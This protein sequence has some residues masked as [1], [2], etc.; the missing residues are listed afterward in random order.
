MTLVKQHHAWRAESHQCRI[1]WKPSERPD[2]TGL[3]AGGLVIQ[4]RQ[5]DR[6]QFPVS[7][8]QNK[9]ADT[10]PLHVASW[11]KKTKRRQ[12][13]LLPSKT[14]KSLQLQQIRRHAKMGIS[15]KSKCGNLQSTG[16]FITNNIEGKTAMST[17]GIANSTTT[18]HIYVS[19]CQACVL[20][21]RL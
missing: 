8:F 1:R 12:N 19:Q 9:L 15:C 13:A 10:Y 21:H 6:A 11:T 5:R 3:G 17:A 7:R 20:E 16:Q 2:K 18:D 14:M 4:S